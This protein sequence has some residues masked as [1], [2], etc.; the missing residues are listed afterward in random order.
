MQSKEKKLIENE[1]YAGILKKHL[2]INDLRK[3]RKQIDIMKEY[4]QQMRHEFV[5]HERKCPDKYTM[6]ADYE[7]GYL[8]A[9][10]NIISNLSVEIDEVIYHY[11]GTNEWKAWKET[12]YNNSNILATKYPLCDLKSALFHDYDNPNTEEINRLYRE[13]EIRSA[14]MSYDILENVKIRKDIQEKQVEERTYHV[15]FDALFGNEYSK[16]RQIR[17]LIKRTLKYSGIKISGK[18]NVKESNE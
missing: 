12:G 8:N 13:E 15:S 7:Y 16:E 14:I 17:S 10:N 11:F 5:L 1:E 4:W 3:F 9:I 6:E 18:M 2:D